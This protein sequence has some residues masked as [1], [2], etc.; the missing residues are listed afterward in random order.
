M[1]T[2]QIDKKLLMIKVHFFL[3]LAGSAPIIPFLSTISMQRGYSSVI[4]GLI[5]TLLPLP[6][7]IVRPVVGAMTDKYKCRKIVLITLIVIN[8]LI[9]CVLMFIPGTTIKTEI[10]DVNVIKSP[11]FWLFFSTIAMLTTCTT[12]RSVLEN[13]ICIGLLG[14]NKHKYGQ[15]RVWGAVGWGTISLLSGAVIDWFSK[16]QDYK[17]YTP[18]M[19]IALMACILDISVALKIEVVEN[20]EGKIEGSNVKK[21]LTN[22]RVLSFLLW[23]VAFGFFNAFIWY[24]LFWYLEDLSKIYHPETIPYIKTLEGL[25][26]TIQC[27]GGEVPF[28][29]LSS[30]ILKRV[31][32]MKVFSLM[33]FTFAVRFFL[34]SIITNPFY[35]LPVELLNGLT[36]AL[37]YSAATSYVSELAPVGAEGTLQGIL[38]T[39]L[40][41]IGAPVGSFVGGHIFD[42]FG[43]ITSFKILSGTALAICITHTTVHLLMNRYS[44]DKNFKENA[45]STDGPSIV[46]IDNNN[47]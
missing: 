4:V 1:Y 6:A 16:G 38:G 20:S 34:Y 8:C 37:A 39:A 41:G 11:T 36:Y 10:A 26:Q 40:L 15:Q 33:F 7:L 29:F 31:D 28:F 46:G 18:G 24:Y 5:F 30:Y 42:R 22:I 13:T 12:A 35:V 23:V 19:I 9:V 43:S 32:N 3:V 27:F 47:L 44:K 21:L 25:T 45:S 17:N 14:E 2:F